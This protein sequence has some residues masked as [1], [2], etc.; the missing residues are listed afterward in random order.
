MLL[1]F[2]LRDTVRLLLN[3]N[4]LSRA[5]QIADTAEVIELSQIQEVESAFV[6]EMHF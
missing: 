5:S 3:E 4:L 2:S 6:R 1:N